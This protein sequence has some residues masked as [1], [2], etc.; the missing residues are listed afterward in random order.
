[1]TEILLCYGL[2]VPWVMFDFS[3]IFSVASKKKIPVRNW[4]IHQFLPELILD[5]LVFGGLGAATAK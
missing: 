5:C 2:E 4:R 1:M 3:F